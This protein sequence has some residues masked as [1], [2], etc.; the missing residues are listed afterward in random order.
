M[1]AAVSSMT[2][3]HVMRMNNDK[4]DDNNRKFGDKKVTRQPSAILANEG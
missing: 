1:E 3:A 4:K 2:L